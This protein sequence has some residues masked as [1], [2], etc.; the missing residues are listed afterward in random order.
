VIARNFRWRY[1]EIDMVA[2]KGKTLV[3][4]EV[5]GGNDPSRIRQKMDSSKLK[6]IQFTAHRFLK[7]HRLDFENI[8]YDFI[9]IV[10]KKIVHHKG[11]HP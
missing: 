5:K 6:K 7:F 8:R 4:V 2:M 9:E 11:I 10:G 3:F 1:G